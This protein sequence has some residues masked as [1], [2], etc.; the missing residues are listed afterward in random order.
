M[1]TS[2][3]K[4]EV[5]AAFDRAAAAYDRL[6]VEFFTPMGHRLVDRLAPLPGE[7][8]L[9]VGCGR[10]ACVFPAAER[11]G[12]NGTVVGI[13]I[14]PGMIEETT[15]EAARQGVGNVRLRVMDGERP[16]FPEGSF[17]V[18]TG[19]YSVIF[20]PDAPAALARYARLLAG[21]GRIGFTTP[22]FTD[23][24]FPFL[25]PVFTELIPRELLRNLPPEWR[26]ERLRQ[27]FNSW[28]AD[29]ADLVRT[30]E[31]CGFRDV[32]C[33]DE[34]VRLVAAS[35]TAWVEWSHTQGMRLLW[36]HLGP[37]DREALRERLVS[38]LDALRVDGGP[39]TI[40]TPVRYVTAVAAR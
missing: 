18:V 24:T 11:V 13:D 29:P 20:F 4:S 22:V 5:A 31:G 26:P 9:D 2:T 37:A 3:Y 17:D 7:R 25:P 23:D 15:K 32:V 27:R 35:G 10:G 28:L 34:T 38:S 12:A 36:E 14:A 21:R 40:D 30:L 19:S 1:D 39:L 16:D 6:G 33:E 8:V